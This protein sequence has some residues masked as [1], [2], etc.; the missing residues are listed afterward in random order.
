MSDAVQS[1][2]AEVRAAVESLKAALDRHLTA[3][4]NR[5]GENDP[6]VTR[7]F[8]ELSA[9]A[10]AYDE[11]LYDAYDEVIPFEVPGDDRPETYE[12]PEQPEAI[13]VLVRRD[14]LI[15]EPSVLV[16]HARR[17]HAAGADAGVG[18][19][20]ADGAESVNAALSLLFNQYEPDE[21]ATRSEEFGLEEGDSTLWVTA[22]EP[23]EPGEWLNDPFEDAD[24]RRAICRF[25]VS[26]VFDDDDDDFLDE[27]DLDEE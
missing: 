17:L 27:E 26:A 2:A 13:S 12:G 18:H 10:D 23:T 7:A 16:E 4:E 14:Y 11:I 1:S 22:I 20:G 6:A 5:S 19:V 21:I 9:A 25:D 8:A 3:V 24:P 15:A